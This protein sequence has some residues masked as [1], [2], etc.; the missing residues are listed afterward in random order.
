[1][2]ESQ[3]PILIPTEY[4]GNWCCWTA[5]YSTITNFTLTLL[6]FPFIHLPTR[7]RPRKLLNDIVQALIVQVGGSPILGRNVGL[8]V[9]SKGDHGYVEMIAKEQLVRTRIDLNR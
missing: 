6:A 9:L 4:T 7:S 5:F 8:Q 1:M 2:R 3:W